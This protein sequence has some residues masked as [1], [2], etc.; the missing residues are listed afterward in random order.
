MDRLNSMAVFVRAADLGSFA[1]AANELGMSAT[2]VGKHVRFLEERLRVPLI[3]R[4]TRRQTLTDFGRTYYERCRTIL[5]EADA[6]D[7]LATDQLHA[8]H[9]R[10]RVTAPVHFGR[11]CVLPVLLDLAQR[12]PELEMDVSFSDRI[13]DLAED[14]HDLAIRTGTL[15]PSQGLVARRVARQTMIVCAAPSYLERHGHPARVEDLA[16]HA[17]LVYR[18]A[19]PVPPWLFPREGEAPLEIRPPNRMRLD[20]LDAI[21][22]AACAGAGIAWLPRWL[23][24]AR[25]RAGAL[26]DVFAGQPG[27][28]YDVHAVWP[29]APHVARRIRVA[30]DALAAALPPMME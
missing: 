5:A 28:L 23:V 4:T 27:F 14:G 17:A 12:F 16:T 13:Q 25:V 6:A 18:R 30:V 1:A 29:Q 7:A 19:G 2:M 3:N 10:L 26:V 21:A 20:D 24:Q 15:P 9:G 11:H 8:L 22:D